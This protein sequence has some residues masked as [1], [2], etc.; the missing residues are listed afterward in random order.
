MLI[1]KDNLFSVLPAFLSYLGQVIMNKL[2]YKPL[3]NKNIFIQMYPFIFLYIVECHFFSEVW[4]VAGFFQRL[5]ERRALAP[6]T[7]RLPSSV[8]SCSKVRHW[9]M[10]LS[11]CFLPALTVFS[12]FS[13]STVPECILLLSTVYRISITCTFWKTNLPTLLTS[14]SFYL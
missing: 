4:W 13:F 11:S 1:M 5:N 8:N 6:S 9:N 2:K 12:I 3:R 14:L 7:A 10:L